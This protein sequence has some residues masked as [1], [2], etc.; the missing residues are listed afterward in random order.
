M[1]LRLWRKI[2]GERNMALAKQIGSARAAFINA[3]VLFPRPKW[4]GN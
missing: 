1:A 2:I 4:H 3:A